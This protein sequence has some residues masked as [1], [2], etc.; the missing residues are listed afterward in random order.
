MKDGFADFISLLK[1][2]NDI[3]EVI[4]SYIKLE[5][6]GYNY[7]ACCPFHHEKTPSFSINA[8]EQF[9]HCFGCGTSGDVIAFVKNYENV[10]FSH[11]VEILAARVGLE[12]PA[13]DDQNREE[14]RRRKQLRDRLLLL[15]KDAARFYL[16][17]LYSGK[18]QAHLE[19]LERRKVLP[20]IM[21][22]FGLGASLDYDSLPDY[23]RQKGY[24]AEEMEQSGVCVR[25]ERGRLWDAQA[26]RLIIPIINNLDEVIAF[27]GRLLEKADRAK[28]K[29]TKDTILFDKRKNL[30]NINL[31]K[32]LHRAGGIPYLILVEGYMDV[33]SL[34]Q[35]GFENVVASMGTSLTKEQLRLCKRYSENIYISY[36][37]DFA[38]QKAN[39]RGL[40]LAEREGLKVKIVPLPDGPDPDDIIREQGA[41]GYRKLLDEA[42][43][44][45]DFRMLAAKRKFDLNTTEGRREYV[46]E[47]LSTIRESES[48]AEKEELLKRLSAETNLS[49]GALKSDLGSEQPSAAPVREPEERREDSSKDDKIAE[50]FIL[51]ACLFQKPYAQN[52]PIEQLIFRD[53]TQE[54][55]ASYI[56]EE[57]DSKGKPSPNGL[58]ELGLDEGEVNSIF[59]LATGSELDGDHAEKYFRDCVFAVRR[60]NLS[61]QIEE[62]RAAYEKAKSAEEKREYLELLGELTKKQKQQR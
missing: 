28:Y 53:P 43:P 5:R 46:K 61:D 24:T 7:W 42:M 40:G 36:D 49:L 62:C 54:K 17:N 48:E 22:K 31:V 47:A 44:L 14:V 34:Y 4:G 3:T 21:K 50:R 8:A 58:F 25:S 23:L 12:V 13:F 18:A 27:G 57:C 41:E 52:F 32:R 16:A 45:M 20:S 6:R 2:K 56:A 33:I 30:Y 9:Y 60:R 55:I 51:A 10:D 26:G 19:Y 38:G 11:A 29:N 39:L 1:Q 37:G 35:A 15:T 59:D